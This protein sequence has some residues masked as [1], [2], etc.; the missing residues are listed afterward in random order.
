VD[1]GFVEYI[2]FGQ[3]R[4]RLVLCLL[5]WRP[6]YCPRAPP[7][8]FD[9]SSRFLTSLRFVL[10]FSFPTKRIVAECWGPPNV[11]GG[12]VE[13]R[14]GAQQGDADELQDAPD[15]GRPEVEQR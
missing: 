11:P 8:L 7:Y 5:A 15:A 6:R 1:Q 2:V 12:T 14:A 13:L 3:H 10:S 9:S 4:G